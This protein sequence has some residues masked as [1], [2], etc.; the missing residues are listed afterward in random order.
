MTR[1]Q[2]LSQRRHPRILERE[3]KEKGS[4]GATTMTMT[5]LRKLKDVRW[6]LNAMTGDY[7]SE[8][9]CGVP[10]EGPAPSKHNQSSP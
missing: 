1:N 7:V 3:L 6:K 2:P 4:L 8:G 5:L 9:M 10:V